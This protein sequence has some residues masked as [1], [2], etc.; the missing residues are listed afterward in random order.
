MG[1]EQR[2]ADHP[3]ERD[4][5]A[6]RRRI[7][8]RGDAAFRAAGRRKARNRRLKRASRTAPGRP[9]GRADGRR[10][11]ARRW[12]A[13]W[14]ATNS[15]TRATMSSSRAA[16]KAR[17][18]EWP[19]RRSMVRTRGGSAPGER[20]P[21]PPSRR[22]R[23]PAAAGTVRPSTMLGSCIRCLPSVG[24]VDGEVHA[25]GQDAQEGAVGGVGRL[26]RGRARPFA[27][28]A[29]DHCRDTV[30]TVSCACPQ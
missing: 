3:V 5:E 6:A 16:S 4:Q 25:L 12:P 18:G 13:A 8:D 2:Q 7:V 26:G 23:C 10:S 19:T 11:E 15:A 27:D 14:P 29:A 17:S 9:A 1:A 22:P 28:E 20:W 24:V 30:L 21:R